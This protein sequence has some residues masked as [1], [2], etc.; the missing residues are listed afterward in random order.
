MPLSAHYAGPSPENGLLLSFAGFT[1]RELAAAAVKLM[2][3][4]HRDLRA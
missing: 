3:G 4:L 1:E 2:E